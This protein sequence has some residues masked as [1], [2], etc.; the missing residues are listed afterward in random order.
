MRAARQ[1]LSEYMAFYDNEI[2]HQA[3]GSNAKGSLFRSKEQ[4]KRGEMKVLSTGQKK[5]NE[6]G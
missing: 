4:L 3:L 5:M 1:S 6:N 2:P